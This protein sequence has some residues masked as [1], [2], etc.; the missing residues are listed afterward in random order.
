VRIY[1][2]DVI[3]RLRAGGLDVE[4]VPYAERVG[5]ELRARYL[6]AER[7]RAPGGDIYRCVA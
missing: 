5:P 1:A 3:E 4:L 6:L 7:G 2:P